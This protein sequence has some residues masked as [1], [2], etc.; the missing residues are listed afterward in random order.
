MKKLALIALLSSMVITIT[1]PVVEVVSAYGYRNQVD[2][3]GLKAGYILQNGKKVAALERTNTD[4]SLDNTFGTNGV[5]TTKIATQ[6]SATRIHPQA[7]G[8]IFVEGWASFTDDPLTAEDRFVFKARYNSNGTLDT[9][10][11]KNGIFL[12]LQEVKL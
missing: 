12:E 8:K 6:S 11:N 10:Y 7:D 1:Y 5:V 3:K 2:G 4:G 9:T